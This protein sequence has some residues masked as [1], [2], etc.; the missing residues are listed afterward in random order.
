M[1]V[2]VASF[3][4]TIALFALAGCQPTAT[5]PSPAAPEVSMTTTAPDLTAS[6]VVPPI[7]ASVDGGSHGPWVTNVAAALA[8]AKAEKKDLLLDFTGSDWCGWCIRL[9]EEVFSKPEFQAYAAKNFVLVELDFPRD[10]SRM[11]PEIE[12]QNDELQSKYGIEGFPTILL[13]DADGLP[14]AQTG[15]QEGGPLPYIE[16]LEELKKKRTTRDEALT[17]AAGLQGVERAKKLDEA[18]AEIPP[19]FVTAAYDNLVSEIIQ[20][21]ADNG[22][23]L[24]AAYETKRLESRFAAR[25]KQIERAAEGTPESLLAEIQKAADEFGTYPA[26]LKQLQMLR[27]RV[28]ASTGKADD[29]GAEVA[30]ALAAEGLSEEERFEL[31]GI[32]IQSLGGA[33]RFADAHKVAEAALTVF[34]AKGPASMRLHMLRASLFAQDRK[35]AEAKAALQQARALAGPELQP[36]FDAIEARLTAD[37]EAEAASEK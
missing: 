33:K 1:F 3:C 10:K 22:A 32:H 13:V 27:L 37:L 23:G 18:V 5:P 21:D 28:L 14:Y 24:K 19:Q 25:V 4:A 34:G 36:R 6:S 20:L 35:G 16:H 7:S 9:N 2:R 12:Q 8:Q 17:A 29:V 31:Y 30:T 11:A 15:Y 26:G